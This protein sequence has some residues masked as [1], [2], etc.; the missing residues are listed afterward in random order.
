[1]IPTP[2]EALRRIKENWLH[3]TYIATE[4]AKEELRKAN[5]D[6]NDIK[7][8][9]FNPTSVSQVTYD[10]E[11]KNWKIKIRGIAIDGEELTIVIAFSEDEFRIITAY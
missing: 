7:Q 4:H 8:V 9:I 3:G 6:M 1:M 10:N 2:E 11:Y 5:C